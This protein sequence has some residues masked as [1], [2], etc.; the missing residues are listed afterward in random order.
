[1]RYFL[2][3][4]STVSYLG[5]HLSSVVVLFLVLEESATFFE[6][7]GVNQRLVV[8]EFRHFGNPFSQHAPLLSPYFRGNLF[9]SSGVMLKRG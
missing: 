4:L 1:M 9:S 2:A 5:R 3:S 8:E 6:F 7:P